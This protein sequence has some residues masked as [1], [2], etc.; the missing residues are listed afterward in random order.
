MTKMIVLRGASN[1]GKT[2]TIKMVHEKL[3]SEYGC[4]PVKNAY[5]P[6]G[7]GN[8]FLD[9]LQYGHLK[10][11]VISEGDYARGKES[12]KN[13]LMRIQDYN[14]DII[15]CV[16]TTDKHKE[17]IMACLMTFSPIFIDT[18]K[19]K[20]EIKKHDTECA[21]KVIDTILDLIEKRNIV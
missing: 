21:N 17:S 9:V 8:D 15:V 19:A 12:V 2:T 3:I 20:K 6:L 5:Q 4:I 11:C 1:T 10:I 18:N 16:C 14:C 13:L 7:N